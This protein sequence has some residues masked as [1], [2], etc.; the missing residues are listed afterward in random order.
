MDNTGGELAR[1]DIAVIEDDPDLRNLMHSILS[2]AGYEIKTYPSGDE[3]L[4]GNSFASLY[5]I[6]MNLGQVSGIDICRYLKSKTQAN[7][8][9]VIIVSAN[10]DAR[11]LALDACA[12]DTL[13]KPFQSKDLLSLVK[14]YLPN[15]L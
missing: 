3:V 13:D 15:L 8:P 12:D 2:R 14:K 9:T 4:K 5:I 7:P 6:D 10:P 1:K 11:Q